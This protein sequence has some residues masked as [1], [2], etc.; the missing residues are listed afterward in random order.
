[1]MISNRLLYCLSLFCITGYLSIENC[2]S[3]GTNNTI[4][5][6]KVIDASTKEPMPYVSVILENTTSGTLTDIKGIYNIITSVTAYKINFSFIGYET[7]S[8]IIYPGQTQILNIELSPVTFELNEVVIKPEKKNYSNRNNPAVDLI[9]Q[10]IDNKDRNRKEGLDFYNYKKYEKI[11]F[12]LSNISDDFT[13]PNAFRDFQFVLDN[14][15]TSRHDGKKNIP[16]YINEIHSEYYS[17][18]NPKADKEIIKAEKTINFDEYIDNKGFRANV[19]YL[20]QNIDIYDNEIFFLSNKFLSPVSGTAPLLYRYYIIDTSLVD[21]DKCYKVFFEPRNPADFLFHGFLFITIDSSF[22]IRKIDMSF[23]KKINIDWVNDVR[24]VQEFEKVHEK[25]WMITKDE[26]SVDFGLSP[27]IM[28]MRGQKVAYYNNYS[29][30][31]PIADSVFKGMDV[32]VDLNEY[33]NNPNYWESARTIPLSDSERQLYIIV[34]SAKQVP[35]FKR[36]MV[37]V[38]LLSTSYLN[39]GKI[40]IGPVGNF[41]SFNETEGSR[42]RFGGRTTTEFN[43][44][45]YLDSYVAYGFKD[46]QYK[47]NLGLTYSLTGKSI[48]KFPVKSIRLNYQYETEIPGQVLNY[49]TKDNI[50]LSFK[51]GIDDKLFYN[52]LFKVEYLNEF[53]NHFSYALGYTFNKQAPGGN[54][55]FSTDEG[56]LTTNNVPYIN[57]SEISLKLRYAPKE[58][59]YEGRTYRSPIPSKYP[60]INLQGTFGSKDLNSDYD[61]QKI[62]FSISRRFYFSIVGYTDIAAEAGKIFGQV[63]YPLLTIHNANQTYAYQ[64]N[65]YNMMNFLEFVSDRYISMN[66]D[67]S[68]NGFFLNKVPLLK[69]L[70]FRE[71]ATFK[72]L[73]GGVSSKNDPDLNPDLFKFPTSQDGTPL[74]FSLEEKPYIEASI[75]LS[76]I[77]RILRVDLIKRFS[78]LDNPNVSSVGVRVQFRLDI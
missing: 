65:S 66:V 70:K 39:L 6:G 71:V 30:N 11:V 47:Y 72:I 73:Y 50:L 5:K 49:A 4:I 76:N 21:N 69:K 52:R 34:D 16:L 51:R 43:K 26:V 10:V 54:L 78:Y 25:A 35:S 42:V 28:G 74:T 61:Y 20:Y 59:F 56:S 36:K 14:V 9:G 32:T 67:H 8:R 29:I 40:E 24:I 58:Q 41:Y 23:N 3:Q 7:E 57:I 17:R 62:R 22:A 33:N 15:D 38:M 68:F 77:L 13:Q 1:M 31:E 37:V 75:G 12:S 44:W 45:I 55:Y 53:E 60:V 18:K 27:E 64:K 46:E 19:D 63:P 48:Y 2:Y